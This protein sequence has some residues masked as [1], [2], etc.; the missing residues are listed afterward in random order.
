MLYTMLTKKALRISF[1]AHKDQVDKTGIPYV[2]HPFCVAE[3]LHTE[4][5]VCTALLHDVVEDTGITLD[6][7]RAAGFPE[8]VTDALALLTHDDSVSYTDYVKARKQNPIARAV[9]LADL[10]HNSDVSRLDAIDDRIRAR[11][12]K[13]AAAREYLLNPD[14]E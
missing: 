4:Y 1:D 6:D 9:K 14:A 8:D 5:E 2:Y 13:Y 3:K 10:E 11:L 12:D 7:L